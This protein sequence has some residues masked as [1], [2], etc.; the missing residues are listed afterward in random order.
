MKSIIKWLMQNKKRRYH[1]QYIAV[2]FMGNKYFAATFEF[3]VSD[4]EIKKVGTT[5]PAGYG[6]YKNY[7][8]LAKYYP[9]KGVSNIHNF[10]TIDITKGS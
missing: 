6:F 4:R 8:V 1:F 2:G 7:K 10:T 9:L 3:Y 5:S